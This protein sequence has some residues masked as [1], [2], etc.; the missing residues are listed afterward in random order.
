[1]SN[2]AQID[3]FLWPFLTILLE[4]KLYDAHAQTKTTI[5]WRR[6][7]ARRENSRITDQEFVQSLPPAD[8][9][10]SIRNLNKTFTSPWW[11]RKNEDVVAIADLSMDIPKHG[12]FVL[13][14]SNG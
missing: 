2:K 3:I 5:S 14:G 1:M 13:L 4:S 8:T 10:I 6:L 7:W 12:I 9:A 11:K